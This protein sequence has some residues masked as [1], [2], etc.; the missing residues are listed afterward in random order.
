MRRFVL[1]Q[2]RDLGNSTKNTFKSFVGDGWMYLD[3]DRELPADLI[4]EVDGEQF[5]LSD[6]SLEVYVYAHQYWW[7]EAEIDWTVGRKVQLAL[8]RSD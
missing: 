4:L 6:A 2:E 5:P 7:L 3:V 1:A 8:Y